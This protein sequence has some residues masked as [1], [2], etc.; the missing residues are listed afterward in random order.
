MLSD[1]TSETTGTAKWVTKFDFAHYSHEKVLFRDNQISDREIALRNIYDDHGLSI[2]QFFRT[3]DSDHARKTLFVTTTSA[4]SILRRVKEPRCRLF[5]FS[6]EQRSWP[7][8]MD[9][10]SFKHY[11]TF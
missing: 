10:I 5:F 8:R 9:V 7:S 6:I 11:L 1:N 4:A 2:V 3:F